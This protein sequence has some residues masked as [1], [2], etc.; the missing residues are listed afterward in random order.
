MR[1]FKERVRNDMRNDSITME[2]ILGWMF[3]SGTDMEVAIENIPSVVYG[4]KQM[5]GHVKDPT[6]NPSGVAH[7]TRVLRKWY[8]ETLHVEPGF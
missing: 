2:H 1:P 8:R 4:V 3:E 5:F 7:V 6:V